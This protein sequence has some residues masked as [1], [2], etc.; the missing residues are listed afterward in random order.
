M[1]RNYF[2][3]RFMGIPYI[4]PRTGAT[5]GGVNAR[6]WWEH[7]VTHDWNN[8]S[9]PDSPAQ[10]GTSRQLPNVGLESH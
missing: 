2:T 4:N 1:G 9:N 3:D 7:T 10:W 6:D 5:D 8:T